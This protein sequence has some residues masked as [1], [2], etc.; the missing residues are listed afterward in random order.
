QPTD[1]VVIADDFLSSARLAD[2]DGVIVPRAAEGQSFAVGGKGHA[3]NF[4]LLGELKDLLA[5]LRVP[6]A[7][8]L[9]VASRGQGFAVGRAGKAFDDIRMALQL[10]QFF[11]ACHVPQ[12]NLSPF[13]R[14]GEGLAVRCKTQRH[15]SGRMLPGVL[16]GA[17][18]SVKD[19]NEVADI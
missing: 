9:V 18:A 12:R 19:S 8:S 7:R 17:G 11:A 16:D 15:Y 4:G 10:V 1:V 5:V 2:V 6:Q 13:S 3:V 14:G